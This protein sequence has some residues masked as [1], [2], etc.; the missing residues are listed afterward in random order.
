M[1]QTQGASA[2]GLGTLCLEGHNEL[3]LIRRNSFEFG[4]IVM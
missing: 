4:S 3:R 2:L 1:N